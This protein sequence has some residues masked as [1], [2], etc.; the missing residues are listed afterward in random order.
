MQP[1]RHKLFGFT[2]VDPSKP[3]VIHPVILNGAA[4]DRI[5]AMHQ[6]RGHG[7]IGE[8]AQ[9]TKKTGHVVI[10]LVANVEEDES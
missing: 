8:F 10:H 6:E 4:W 1:P 3:V 5:I 7:P 9:M 2:P